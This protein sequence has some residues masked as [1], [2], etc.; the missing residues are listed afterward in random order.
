M[1][2]AKEK[3]QNQVIRKLVYQTIL[4]FGD[5]LVAQNVRQATMDVYGKVAAF[6]KAN[7]LESAK[8]LT[9]VDAVGDEQ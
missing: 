1:P 3:A 2:E 4:N 6:I 9:S 7:D 8:A 5:Q